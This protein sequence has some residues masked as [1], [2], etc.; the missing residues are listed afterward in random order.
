MQCLQRIVKAVKIE[1]LIQEVVDLAVDLT[2]VVVV[3]LH[4][5]THDPTLNG[6]A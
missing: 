1:A 5:G 3:V 6:L 4:R 2:K